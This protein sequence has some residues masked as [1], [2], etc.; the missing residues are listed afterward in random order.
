MGGKSHRPEREYR[1]TQAPAN[2]VQPTETSVGQNQSQAKTEKRMVKTT[3]AMLSDAFFKIDS[4]KLT[5]EA[6]TALDPVITTLHTTG[7]SGNIRLTGHTCDLGSDRHNQKLSQLR[8]LAVKKY[9]VETGPL[10]YSS[11]RRVKQRS[12]L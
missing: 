1:L 10:I 3:A 12:N 2:T 6:R 8:A 9:L 5:P 4:D 7:Y 11:L